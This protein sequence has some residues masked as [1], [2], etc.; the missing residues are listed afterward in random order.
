M[1]PWEDEHAHV[2]LRLRPSFFAR[3]PDG[4][5]GLGSHRMGF[6]VL[7]RRLG[8][9]PLLRGWPRGRHQGSVE[10]STMSGRKR[11]LWIG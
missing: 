8:V 2:R 3:A 1:G 7:R 11:S 9:L 6:Q 10:G 4:R 5:A